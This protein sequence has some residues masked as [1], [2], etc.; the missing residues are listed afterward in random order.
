M[1]MRRSHIVRILNAQKRRTFFSLFRIFSDQRILTPDQ[2]LEIN[3]FR[4][5]FP[6]CSSF[7]S[8]GENMDGE[9]DG[10]VEKF[11]QGQKAFL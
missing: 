6:G 1:L 9:R 3:P 8:L 11:G 7:E 5:I 4:M 10:F 2:F